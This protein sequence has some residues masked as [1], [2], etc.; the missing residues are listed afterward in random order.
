MSV[1]TEVLGKGKYAITFKAY[2]ENGSVLTVKWLKSAN[3]P[4]AVFKERIAEIGAIEHELIV[5]LRRYYFS[6]YEK[7]LVYDYFPNGSLSSNLHGNTVL[8]YELYLDKE[9]LLLTT[10]CSNSCQYVVYVV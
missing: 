3:V 5:P 1:S 7:V 6:N 4:E 2:L 8:I 9:A 10:I